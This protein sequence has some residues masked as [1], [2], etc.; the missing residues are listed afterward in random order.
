MRQPGAWVVGSNAVRRVVLALAEALDPR[1]DGG[2]PRIGLKWPNDLWLLDD[3]DAPAAIGGNGIGR[4]LGG[5]LIE[6]V[7][8][9][10]RRL[11]VIGI[12]LNVRPLLLRDSEAQHGVACLQEI[13]A[14]MEAPGALQ[15]VVLPLV[16][17]LQRFE[18][19]GFAPFAQAFAARD[20]LLGRCVTTTLPDL[21]DGTARGVAPDG[22]LLVD[23]P[24]GRISLNSGEVSIRP[25][26]S[27]TAEA[28]C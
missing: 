11:A 4:K 24:A 8:A 1:P 17:A 26:A 12:G 9:G 10:P 23:G 21:A 5:I 27:G 22:C 15:R 14:R 20:L 6:T 28:R 19:E 7:V 16:Q 25:T 3:A 13:D 18:R 2:P